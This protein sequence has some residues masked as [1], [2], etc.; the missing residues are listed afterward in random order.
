VSSQQSGEDN[1]SVRGKVSLYLVG[2]VIGLGSGLLAAWLCHPETRAGQ[3]GRGL[4]RLELLTYDYRLASSATLGRSPDLAIV[5]MDEESFQQSKL[6]KWSW[7]RRYYAQAIRNLNKAGAKLIAL[8]LLLAGV[9]GEAVNSSEEDWWAEPAASE[10]DLELTAALREAGNVVLAME[11]ATEAVAGHEG[12]AEL[13]TATF[14]YWEFE[15]AALALGAANLPK[16]LDGVARR[17]GTSVVHQDE[18]FPTM[19]LAVVA[20]YWDQAPG[21]LESQVLAQ[22]RSAH[23]ALAGDDFLI[24][25]R[26]PVGSG[27]VRMPFYRLLDEEFDRAQIAEQVAG[28]LVLIGP[29]ARSFH[30]LHP[31]P[32][33]M[34]GVAGEGKKMADMPGVEIIAQAT[35][36]LLRSRYILPLAPA[37]TWLLT[38]LGSLLMAVVL[39][40]LRPLL[41]LAVGWLPLLILFVMATFYIFWKGRLWVPITPL[42]LG[43]TLSYV[44]GTVY[45]EL[46]AERQHRRLRRAWA[47][48]VSPEVLAVILDHPELT[49]V[50]GRRVTGTVFFSDLRGFT[51]FCHASPPEEVVEQINCHL[52]LATHVIRKHGGTIH[53]FIGDGIMAVFGDPV[54]QNDHA[55]RALAA[56]IELQQGMATL[57]EEQSKGKWPMFLRI[58]L[59]TG[60]LVAGDI[61][62]EDMLEYTVMGDTVSTASRLEGMNKEFGTEI[63][64]SRATAERVGEGFELQ[65][66]GEVQV[67]GRAEPLEVYT[68]KEV[69]EHD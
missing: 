15:D 12:G 30:D 56:S 37:A 66:L 57:R 49:A 31:T 19:A 63:L 7:P 44:L 17:Y 20:A 64:M 35:D 33:S 43:V 34:R 29:T 5:S 18:R 67:R 32:V 60:E 62:S 1:S 68:V 42:V 51:T 9:S 58:G 22:A 41:A 47:K 48:R 52:T 13:I 27:F 54:P 6:R 24:S 25:Y 55:R 39:I 3:L 65:S 21:E 23:P 53:K 8:D 14:P 38:V 2:L 26:A 45:L 4:W 11:V 28:K 61:G 40:R 16:D 10:D 50:A 59:H 36:A 46:T 69:T